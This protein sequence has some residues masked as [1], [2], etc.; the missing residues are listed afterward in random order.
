[1]SM[2]ALTCVLTDCATGTCAVNGISQGVIAAFQNSA[3]PKRQGESD[4]SRR[5]QD[6]RDRQN[7]QSHAHAE[8]LD[9][10]RAR[11]HLKE[12]SASR[13]IRRKRSKEGGELILF[14]HRFPGHNF[15]LEVDNQCNHG[16]K[17]QQSHDQ[18][19]EA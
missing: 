3:C 6:Q 12:E 11:R 14:L 17:R 13:Q 5:P 1:M 19:Q 9:N 2:I 10:A 15:E 8:F 7:E 16:G 4:E 18:L